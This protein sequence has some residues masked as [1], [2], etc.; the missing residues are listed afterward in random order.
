VAFVTRCT[1]I[2][3]LFAAL[4]FVGE[5]AQAQ[6]NGPDTWTGATDNTW[7]G[8]NWTGSN[9]PPISGD[10]LVFGA[11]GA[12][13]TTLTDN[14]MTPATFTV[15]GIT[16]N[17][18]A[19]AFTL[20]PATAGTNGFTLTTG[21][22][23]NGTSLE[24][25][26][27][28]IALSGT[29]TFTTTAGGGNITLGGVVS[30]SGNLTATGTGTQTLTGTNSYSG[31]T[32]V[33][34]GKLLANGT[35]S[36][37]SGQV[38]VASGGTLGGTGTITPSGISSGN[39][40]TI[41]SGGTLNQSIVSGG[42]GTSTLT[43]ALN[44]GSTVNLVGGATFAFNLGATGASDQVNITGGTLTLNNQNFSNFTFTTLSGFT[45]TGTYDLFVTGGSGDIMGSLG[46]TTGSIGADTGTLS[47]LN[48]QDLVLT[49]TSGT[50]PE[51]STWAMLLGGL[52]L[53]AFRSLRP[54]R[55]R[56]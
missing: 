6:S 29:D 49:V 48:S 8:S 24:T 50:V 2:S 37:G 39:A 55:A 46:T 13:G 32:S 40:V 19:A 27:D 56:D 23:N 35:N 51:P 26:N 9:N 10:S 1:R 25:I 3:A 47:I 4:L 54:R 12:G 30:G 14:L 18:G 28:L 43:L 41:Q 17:T 45:G 11:A 5:A 42:L 44:S 31:G 16:F 34:G 38:T 21:I 52:A 36:T 33:N 20:N 22:T 53:L 15:A 7:A